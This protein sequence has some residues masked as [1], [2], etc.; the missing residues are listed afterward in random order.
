MN[1]PPTTAYFRVVN[2]DRFQH[3]A[4]RSPPWIKL[5][6]CLLDDYSFSGLRDASKFHL[7]AIWLLASRTDNKIP[8]DAKWVGKQINATEPV[9][10]DE[11]E[12]L[13]FIKKIKRSRKGSDSLAGG[14]QDAR[15]EGE[16]SRVEGEK[17]GGK[18]ID[19]LPVFITI[20]LVNGHAFEINTTAVSEWQVRYPGVNV[21]QE[22]R[23]MQGWCKANVSKRKTIRGIGRFINGWLAKEQSK[24]V[25]KT[26]MTR[27]IEAINKAN[28]K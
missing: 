21:E 16:Q 27:A 4:D 19:G 2:F 23:K 12:R 8:W 13:D 17:K 3:Y 6:N 11:L 7:I 14:L 18:L 5:Y 15:L 26:K 9:M 10:L 28:Q 1:A 20:P 24:P 25:K 22:L